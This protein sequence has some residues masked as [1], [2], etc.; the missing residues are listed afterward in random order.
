MNTLQSIIFG[1]FN[2]FFCYFICW[3]FFSKRLKFLEEAYLARTKE[4]LL[5]QAYSQNQDAINKVVASEISKLK[6]T[7]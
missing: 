7:K 5:L 3:L 2:F 6:D 4:V 1:I